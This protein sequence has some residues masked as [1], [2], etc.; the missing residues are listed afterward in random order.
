[1]ALLVTAHPLAPLILGVGVWLLL[2]GVVQAGRRWEWVRDWSF[3][4]AIVLTGAAAAVLSGV[5]RSVAD[6]GAA[7]ASG[8]L[9]AA[10]GPPMLLAMV[11]AV[12]ALLQGE[13]AAAKRLLQQVNERE[14]DALVANRELARV[15]RALAED[16]HGTMQS[17]LLA[18]AF[19]IDEAAARNDDAAFRAA[20][21]SAR[22]ALQGA[23]R[24]PVG[25]PGDLVGALDQVAALWKGFIEVQ[26]RVDPSISRV[27]PA[28]VDDIA[29]VAGEALANAHKHG[30]AARVRVAV[31]EQGGVLRITVID[32]GRGPAAGVPGLG[33][34]WLD[35]IAPGAWSLRPRPGEPGAILEVALPS[36][37]RATAL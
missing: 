8:P 21:A 11:S 9:A 20:L 15:T 22:A 13:D 17:R 30:I 16:V 3:P 26:V 34:A 4:I 23:G 24:V 36:G 1:M 7:G 2:E 19:A 33:S 5:V 6:T 31:T 37:D 25:L 12:T 28:T 29:R 10:V 32:D 35:F 27:D 14:I 18:T